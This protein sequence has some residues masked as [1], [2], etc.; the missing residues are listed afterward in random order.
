MVARYK[1]VVII[2]QSLPAVL[3][4]KIF[5]AIFS[6]FAHCT[7]WLIALRQLFASS[8]TSKTIF[9]WVALFHPSIA[10]WVIALLSCRSN[11]TALVMAVALDTGGRSVV[12]VLRLGAGWA[13]VRHGSF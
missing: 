2:Q 5:F 11:N 1:I 6:H 13:E 7:A 8:V 10:V 4:V 3:F 9:R 12:V